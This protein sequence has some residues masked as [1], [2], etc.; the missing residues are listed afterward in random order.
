MEQEEFQYNLDVK[1]RDSLIFREQELKD[2]RD[3]SCENFNGL[4]RTTFETLINE[5][6]LDPDERVNEIPTARQFL[7]F[8][9]RHSGEKISALGYAV[10]VERSDYRVTIEGLEGEQLSHEALVDFSNSFERADELDVDFENRKA[11]CWYD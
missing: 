2:L 4:D 1:R 3:Y 9:Q 8:M 10:C 6:F 11:R 7:D 5:R